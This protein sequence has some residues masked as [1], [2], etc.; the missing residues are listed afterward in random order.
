MQ[1]DVNRT[2]EDE[3]RP[4]VFRRIEGHVQGRILAGLLDLVPFL[5]TV[6]VVI[7]LVEKVD[8]LIRPLPFIKRRTLG[9]SR[10]R[11]D[12]VRCAAL[13]FRAGDPNDWR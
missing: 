12:S 4:S 11:A 8:A 10:N 13:L 6:V 1:P 3:E 9:L 5:V 2:E 7:F